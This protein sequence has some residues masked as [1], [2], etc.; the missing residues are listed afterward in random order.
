MCSPIGRTARWRKTAVY[1]RVWQAVLAQVQEDFREQDLE[2]T[3]VSLSSWPVYS[4]S[5]Q[6][7]HVQ[8]NTSVSQRRAAFPIANT[9]AARHLLIATRKATMGL[10]VGC[11]EGEPLMLHCYRRGNNMM[12][13]TGLAVCGTC[14]PTAD[15][16]HKVCLQPEDK[17]W[18][19]K[20]VPIT[21]IT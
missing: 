5:L 12:L 19:S 7:Y 3:R 4:H 1:Y 20:L 11:D 17:N 9:H 6:K 21:W 2:N 8:S 15:H 10:H 18:E 16:D 13:R 14:A